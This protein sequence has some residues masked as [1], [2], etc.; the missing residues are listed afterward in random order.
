MPQEAKSID[1]AAYGGP[2]WV[3]RDTTLREELGGIWSACGIDSE[4]RR[5]RAVL[6]HRPGAE[7]A[8]AEPD[9]ALMLA[10]LDLGKAQAQHDELAQ[11]YRDHGVE[12]HAIAPDEPAQPNQMFAADLFFMTPEGAVLGRPAS[13]VR[14][15]EE[16]QVARRLAALGVPILR[17]LRGAATFEGADAA[18]L[19]PETVLIGRSLRTNG[20]GA[21]QLRAL[22]EEMGLTVLTVDLPAGAMHLMGLLRLVDRDLAIA[23]PGRTPTAAIEA[24]RDRGIQVAFLHNEAEALTEFRAGM[25]LNFVT[26]APRRILMVDGNPAAQA[27]FEAQ[28]IECLSVAADEL[29]KAAGALGCL[30]GVLWRDPAKGVSG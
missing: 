1:A 24:L 9:A 22:L 17:S 3:G 8:S 30:T 20:A 16:R 7:L 26:L 27:F 13:R 29:A 12:V 15:G 2:G 18:W 25:A 19:D 28:G 6:L 4:W 5:L 14:A 11:A 21:D 10:P 23:W